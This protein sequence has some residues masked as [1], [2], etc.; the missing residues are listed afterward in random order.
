MLARVAAR[1]TQPYAAVP[2][3]RLRVPDALIVLSDEESRHL[4]ALLDEAPRPNARLRALLNPPPRCACPDPI[5]VI[6]STGPVFCQTCG[7]RCG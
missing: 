3:D 7:R 5:A 4:D 1:R 2:L 6:V